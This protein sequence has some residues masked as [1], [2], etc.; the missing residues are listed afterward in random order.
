MMDAWIAFARNGNP[1]H[2][3]IGAWPAYDADRRATMIFGP[4]RKVVDAPFPEEL[5]AWDAAL[6]PAPAA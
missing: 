4:E 6:R 5:A 1:S 2:E 3:R